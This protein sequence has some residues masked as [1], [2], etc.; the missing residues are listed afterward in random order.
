[1]KFAA[2]ERLG[3]TSL[4]FVEQL[5]ALAIFVGHVLLSAMLPRYRMRR[6]LA[7]IFDVGVLSLSIV[8]LSGFAV[9]AVLGLQGYDTLVRFGAEANVG[10]MVG[11][12]LVKE[13]G[14][15]LS[16]LLVIGRAGSATAAQIASMVTTEQLDGLRMMSI[17]PIDF[18]VAPKAMALVVVMPL[19]CALFIV[20]ALAG[21]YLVGV[22][23]LGLHG[24]TY[25][26]SLEGAIGFADDVVPSFSKALVFGAL[27]GFI[28]TYRGYTSEPTSV[29]VSAATTGTVVTAS[30][31]VL[32]FDYVITALWGV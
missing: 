28:S 5:G 4:A 14:P 23:L 13:L 7:E 8:C 2:I 12:S 15:V 20:F 18:V 1:V 10:A 17:D 19:L 29:G 6:F 32:L 26:S 31:C 21:G 22:L 11:L 30:V 16:A 9:G 25:F 24:G 27:V 3:F